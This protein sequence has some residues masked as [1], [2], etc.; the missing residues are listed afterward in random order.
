MAMRTGKVCTQPAGDIAI[1]ER[2]NAGAVAPERLS[3]AM[4]A[5]MHARI[6]MQARIVCHEGHVLDALGLYDSIV[7]SIQ[8]ILS[9]RAHAGGAR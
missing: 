3:D 5:M 9:G 7:E 1:E 8:P 4:L 2:G 6:M